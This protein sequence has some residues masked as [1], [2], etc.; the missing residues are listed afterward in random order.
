MPNSMGTINI[1]SIDSY[2]TIPIA[3]TATQPTN[4]LEHIRIFDIGYNPFNLRPLFATAPRLP[5]SMQ[6]RRRHRL[7]FAQ[8]VLVEINSL[9]PPNFGVPKRQYHISNGVMFEHIGQSF[10]SSGKR[11]S[12][13]IDLQQ[14]INGRFIQKV[15][16]TTN[17]TDEFNKRGQQ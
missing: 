14:H 12:F 4:T 17:I 8:K 3:I 10:I 16:K 11:T 13:S 2:S 1:S 7:P 6:R 9:G 15:P 5:P